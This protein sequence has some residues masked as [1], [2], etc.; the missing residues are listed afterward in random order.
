MSIVTFSFSKES[1]TYENNDE[2]EQQKAPYCNYIAV[3]DF[4][5]SGTKFVILDVVAADV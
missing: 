2:Y 1:H 4:P 5:E 3:M